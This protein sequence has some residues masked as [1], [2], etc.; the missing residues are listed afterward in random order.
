MPTP[1]FALQPAALAADVTLGAFTPLGVGVALWL[2]F[3]VYGLVALSKHPKGLGVLFFVEMWERFS[4]YG[5]RALLL[6]YMRLPVESGGL[7]LSLQFAG[8]IYA[9]YTFFVYALSV[10]GGWVADRF[11]GYRRAVLVGGTLIALGEFGLAT[12]SLALFY[13]GLAAIAIGTGLLKT[14][15]TS[16]VGMLYPKNDPRQDAGYSIY[17]MGINIGA[18]I[19]PLILGFMAQ[20]PVFVAALGKVGF[21]SAN[22]WRT[23]FAAAG[24]AMIAG[25]IQYGAPARRTRT[26]AAGGG[27]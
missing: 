7:G 12:G 8:S 6:L 15:T 25:L 1:V 18:L 21:A 22:G 20:D 17:Y 13:T 27:S 23:A 24:L 9:F 26:T 14:N 3:V 4:Y 10:P 11:L 2:A 19:A 16:L 5:M